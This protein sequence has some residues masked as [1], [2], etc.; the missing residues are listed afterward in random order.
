MASFNGQGMP[1]GIGN[2]PST[3]KQIT[4]YVNQL[5]QSFFMALVFMISGYFTPSSVERKGVRLFLK[6]RFM[7]I[8][9]P[10][11]FYWMAVGPLLQLGINCAFDLCSEYRY[12]PAFG[13]AW[14]CIWL[15]WFNVGYTIV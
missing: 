7:R 10:G 1:V 9:L 14:F 15:M 11:V 5:C 2:Y 3:F 8:A 4:S 6:E 12:N 13:P